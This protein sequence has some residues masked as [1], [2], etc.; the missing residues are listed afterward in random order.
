MLVHRGICV[1]EWKE[2]GY[3]EVEKCKDAAPWA[4]CVTKADMQKVE[5]ETTSVPLSG[6]KN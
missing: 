5:G 3:Q 2:K 1:D 4:L 6:S